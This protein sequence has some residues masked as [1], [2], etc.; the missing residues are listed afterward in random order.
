MEAH[1]NNGGTLVATAGHLALPPS[2]TTATSD[3]SLAT[4][5]N[6]ASGLSSVISVFHAETLRCTP[7]PT[8]HS[9]PIAPAP[10]SKSMKRNSVPFAGPAP[11]N[12]PTLQARALAES[13]R[14]SAAAGTLTSISFNLN[15]PPVPQERRPSSLVDTHTPTGRTHTA[16]THTPSGR[17]NT[18]HTHTHSHR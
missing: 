9:F 2:V 6:P 17:T 13:R 1:N 7:S 5:S 4:L 12:Y 16:H 8:S 18:A 3:T 14:A 15:I 10:M 11:K